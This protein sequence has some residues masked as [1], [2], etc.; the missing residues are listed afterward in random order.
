MRKLFVLCLLSMRLKAI[1]QKTPFE[2]SGKTETATYTEA[3]SYYEN[4]AKTYPEAKLLTYGDTDFGK[5][6]HLLVLSRDQVFDPAQIR[7][8][9]KRILLI[10]NGI[11]P[12]EPEGIDASM[13]LARDLL[14]AG[15][16][17]KDVVICI[18]PLYNIDGSFNRSGTSRANQNDPVAYGFRGNGKNLDLNRDFIKTDSKNSATFQLIFNTWQPEIF[19]D[20]HTSNG[21]D[22]QYVMTLI[23]TQKD[24]LN[25]IL[26]DYLTKTLVPDLY[27]GMEKLGYPMIPYVNSIGET[28]ETGITGFIES[29]RY[30]TGYTTLHNTIGFMPET[31]MLKSYDLRVDATY[32][33]LQTYIEVVERDAKIIGEN[34]R[35]AD[36]FVAAQKEFPLEWKLDKTMVNDLTFKG[37]EA[38]Q[39][40]SMVSGADRLYY[41]R[42]KPYTKTIKE[43]NK[44]EPAVSVQKPVAYIIPKAWERVIALL[45]LNN[46]KI[47]ELKA[48]QKIAVES[49]YIGDFKTGT[50]PYEG[51]YLHSGVKVNAVKQNLQYYAGD[52]V[53]YVNQPSNRYI[54]ETLEPQATDSYFNWNFFDSILD[55]KEH[56]SAYVFEDTATELLKN[57]PEL[58]SKLEAKKAS[59]TE[60]AK[61]AAA[62]L[63][64]V[65]KNSDYYEKT[66]NRYPVARLITDVKLDL[67]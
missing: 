30:S 42:N 57:N 54:V 39:K 63:D 1:A 25:P 2:L 21:A 46:V 64:F 43:W 65:Y 38:G 60:F 49:Y 59:D 6:L 62:Q 24:K 33:L 3:I 67:K 17:P 44:F 14:K 19:V 53:I 34:K 23:P 9:N 52:F 20:T 11:H 15:K 27:S 12:G 50:R 47:S 28:P 31:H 58:K 16:L 66:H 40:P 32:K 41:D 61:N 13:M 5:P 35:K 56:Y 51:H 48:N 7:K 37:F 26:S 45:K 18:I 22:Y 8:Q 36:G 55:M 29:P 4:L 10:N